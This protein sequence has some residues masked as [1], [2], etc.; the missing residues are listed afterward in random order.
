MAAAAPVGAF[1]GGFAPGR[2]AGVGTM[3]P[4]V[5]EGV[6][7]GSARRS[8]AASNSSIKAAITSADVRRNRFNLTFTSVRVTQK[9]EVSSRWHGPFNSGEQDLKAA[10]RTGRQ[11]IRTCVSCR[12]QEVPCTC[13]LA[14]R[15]DEVQRRCRTV[16]QVQILV[17]WLSHRDPGVTVER[18]PAAPLAGMVKGYCP[19]EQK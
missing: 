9:R 5:G 4:N 3:V 11:S 6:D 1:C 10:T 19:A 7:A 13:G 12:P 2:M 14:S 18:H 17:L 8:Q 16:L 15:R